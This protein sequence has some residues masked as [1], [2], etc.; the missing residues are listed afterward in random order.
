VNDAGIEAIDLS[1][2]TDIGSIVSETAFQGDVASIIVVSDTKGYAV[3]STPSF[4]TEL[5][6]FNPQTKTVGAKIAGVDAPCS[7]H[8]AYDGMYVYVGDRS[9]TSPG[10]VVIDPTTDLKK[11]STKNVGLPPNSLAFLQTSN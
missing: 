6:P 9:A 1:T 4:T 11:G 2:D 10:I 5:H 8:L 7:G 3:I